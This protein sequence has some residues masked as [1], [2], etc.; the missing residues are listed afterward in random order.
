MYIRPIGGTDPCDGQCEAELWIGS[1]CSAHATMVLICTDCPPDK[2][3]LPEGFH[4]SHLCE[5][6]AK[7]L[8]QKEGWAVH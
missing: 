1:Y 4:D 8:A 6:H 7:E 3:F 2:D 5:L